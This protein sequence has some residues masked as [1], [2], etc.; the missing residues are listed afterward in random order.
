MSQ[1]SSQPS[2]T[3]KRAQV[4]T[5]PTPTNVVRQ[6]KQPVNINTATQA[7]LDA[8]PGVSAKLAARIITARQQRP[9]KSLNDL[10]RI[11]GVGP[12]LLKRLETQVTW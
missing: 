11:S 7:E 3:I 12:K 6:Q 4:A 10:D 1:P 2:K 9:I 5:L 8:I